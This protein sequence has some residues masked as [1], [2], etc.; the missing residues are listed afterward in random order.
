MLIGKYIGLNRCFA[1][2]NIIISPTSANNS[3]HWTWNRSLNLALKRTSRNISPTIGV[4]RDIISKDDKNKP[5]TTSTVETPVAIQL[6]TYGTGRPSTMMDVNRRMPKTPDRDTLAKFPD[7]KALKLI[8]TDGRAQLRV[9]NMPFSEN[10]DHPTTRRS[11]ASQIYEHNPMN[12]A[13]MRMGSK[14]KKTRATQDSHY[15]CPLD[16]TPEE[17]IPPKPPYSTCRNISTTRPEKTRPTTID[18][19]HGQMFKERST[20]LHIPHGPTLQPSIQVL[21][22]TVPRQN[23]IRTRRHNCSH[24]DDGPTRTRPR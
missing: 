1:I 20:P 15:I 5:S 22:G 13:T 12:D 19:R 8:T 11:H 17:S 9:K 10:A 18:D 7:P 2:T 6:P 3:I 14:M 4:E 24:N 21:S 16:D 23:P